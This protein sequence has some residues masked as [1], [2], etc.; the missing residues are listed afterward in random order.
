MDPAPMTIIHITPQ[1]RLGA[2]RYLVDT[3]LEQ[4]L[5]LGHRI[6]VITSTDCDE[7]WRTDPK[8]VSELEHRNIE[9][10]T[11]GDFFRRNAGFLHQA[12]ARLQEICAASAGP[13]MVHA[14]T[15]MAA[16]V[17]HWA[18]PD[19]LVATCH[20][21]GAG[22]PAD[23][24]LEDSLA[25]QLCD[26]VVT[27]SQYW[28]E[29]LTQDMAVA[30]PKVVLMGLDLRRFPPF[31]EHSL[32]NPTPVRMVTV[33]ELT[34]RKGVDLLLH[35]LPAI[36]QQLPEVELH[37][38]GH[39]ESAA[40]LRR[41]AEQVDPGSRRVIFHGALPSP[42]EQLGEFDL[43]VLASRSDNLPVVLLEA[44]LAGLPMAA[45]A[46]G[47]VA[48]LIAAAACGVV[49]PPESSE[50]LAHGILSLL[51]QGRENMRALGRRGERFCRREY[52]VRITAAKL[53]P[54]YRQAIKM[55]ARLH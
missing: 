45:T 27:Y 7:N 23:I 22:R 41:L 55:R 25:Y 33:C 21:W 44:M 2:G 11:L 3:A 16:A 20:G 42:Y 39:G 14:H 38:I 49:I 30:A 5:G 37:I 47:G 15:A 46:V 34:P 10:R 19:G 29:R 50:A 32:L 40:D 36:W 53:E 24:D 8:L 52:D 4:A 17:G 18:R 43:F 31:P 35:A 51:R 1:L 54:V 12:G 6:L 13:L 9:V 26:V 48:E 28:A